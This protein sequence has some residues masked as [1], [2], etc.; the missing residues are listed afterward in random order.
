MIVNC[1]GSFFSLLLKKNANFNLTSYFCKMRVAVKFLGGTQT[2]TGSRFLLSIDD[3]SILVDCGLFQ[4]LK[5]LR[6]RNWDNFP[7]NI[8]EINAVILTHAHID[9]SGYLP[10]LFKEGYAG[11]VYC[12]HPTADLVEILLK[13]S[14]KLQ[15]EEADYAKHKGYSKHENPKPLY[16]INDTTAVFPNLV[17][18]NY[19]QTFQLTDKISITF[20]DASHILGSAIVEIDIKFKRQTKKIVFSGDLGKNKQVIHPSPYKIKKADILFV[21]S[22]YGDRNV[23]GEDEIEN[24]LATIINN[25]INR[26]GILLIPAFAVGRTQVLLYY[27]RKLILEHKIPHIP[28]YVDS[29][30]AIDVTWLYSHYCDLHRLKNDE[31]GDGGIF[32]F[33]NLVYVADRNHSRQLN[34]IKK[35]AIIISASGMMTGGRILH[36]LYQ[37]L[38]RPNTTLLLAGYQA[39]GTR[40]RRIENGEDEIRIFGEMVPVK[41]VVEKIE[42]LSAHADLDDLTDWIKNIK[43]EPKYTFLIHGEEKVMHHFKNHINEKLSWNNVVVPNYLESFELFNMD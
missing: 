37:L 22:T 2:V 35:N 31:C 28:I 23:E 18:Y 15:M 4:G 11:K 10:K 34:T 30:M 5:E 1:K 6:L 39:D 7:T 20:R 9:H 29:P 8:T 14:A 3:Y 24:N 32:S 40:G 21:E 43:K 16:D 33:K 19:N 38:P 12:T 13:D 27:L 36:H 25:A 42:G 26:N 41:C 17:T